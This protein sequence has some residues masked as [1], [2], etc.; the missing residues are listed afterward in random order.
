MMIVQDK[1]KITLY[2]LP[3]AGGR[4]LSYRDFQ[5]QVANFILIKPLELPGRG[6]RMRES[7]LTDLDAM[8]DDVFHQVQNDLNGQPYAIYGHSMGAFLGCLLTQRLVRAGLPAPRH[9]FLSGRMAPS[10]VS[11]KPPKHLLPNECFINYINELGG[12]PSEIL[13]EAELM[14]FLMPILRADFQAIETYVYHPTPPFDIPISILHGLADKET[15]YEEL[16]P[17][18]QETRQPIT[19]IKQFPGGHF[20][21]L[22]Q[23]PQLGQLFSRT[24]GIYLGHPN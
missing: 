11:D 24:L 7:L 5:A 21:I 19:T 23:L 8:V 20:F 18:Q 16:L 15:T 1:P 12:I 13:E 14:D 2:C 17:W 4:A 10:V 3:F 9:L 22:E 6:K